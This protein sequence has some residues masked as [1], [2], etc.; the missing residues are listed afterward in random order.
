MQWDR[1]VI[2]QGTFKIENNV[3]WWIFG[4]AKLNVFDSTFFLKK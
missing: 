2:N 4:V 3:V 1:R